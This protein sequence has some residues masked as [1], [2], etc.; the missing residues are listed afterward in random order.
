MQMS[1][2]QHIEMVEAAFALLMQGGASETAPMEYEVE[3][4]Y[5]DHITA[6]VGE[7]EYSIAYEMGEAGVTFA[8]KESWEE[9]TSEAPAPDAAPADEQLAMDGEPVKALGGGKVGGYLV[10]FSTARDPDV[11]SSRDYFDAKTDLRYPARIDTYYHHGMDAKIGKRVIGTTIAT[12]DGAGLWAETQLN[13][14]DEYERAIYEMAQA[15]KLGYSS[16]AL[17]HL[18]EREPAGK[19]V[20]W[21]KTWAIGE[22]SLTPTPAE[23]RNHATPLKSL[24]NP[25]ALAL[26]YFKTE[27]NK[28]DEIQ[29]AVKAALEAER[30]AQ[31]AIQDRA[32]EIEAA[33]QEGAKAAIEELKSQGALRQSPAYVK[34][35]GKSD[36]G[37]AGFKSW[38]ATGQVNGDLIRPTGEMWTKA[39]FN[40]TTGATGGFLVPD[41]LYN[42]IIAKRNN[43]SWVR[44]APVQMFSVTAD[45]LLIPVEDTSATAFVLTAEA[46]AY[47]Q[48]EPTVAQ[49]NLILYKYTKKVQATEEFMMNQATNFD[50]W[51]S[52]V[53]ARAEAVTENAIFTTGTGT[54]QPQGVEVGATAGNTVTTS[55]VL[56]P[57][58]FS[59]LIGQLGS[60]YNVPSECGFLMQ[61]ATKWYAKGLSSS[62]QFAF[63]PTPAGGP[64]DFFGYTAWVD[65]ELDA[66][67]V[68]SSS[69][70][71]LLFGNFNFYAVGE[72]PGMLVQ[73]DPYTNMGT[74]V[75]N[76]YANIYR[77]G[78]VLQ[79]EAFYYT[80]GK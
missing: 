10:R 22:A 27:K 47:D 64:S 33:K 18:V 79:S 26:G 77:G 62:T 52:Q 2:E 41:P 53:L 17:S 78:L 76:I 14:R 72:K 48:N 25:G 73:R 31:K 35:A 36:D 11:S 12:K 63:N 37:M 68:A 44:Q 3:E 80:Q 1:M 67:T 29:T 19:G 70:H 21:I 75:V 24:P 20:N 61:N 69:G 23:P 45:H 46:A 40:Q 42:Q 60:G 13:M 55:A 38:L 30:A 28:M 49:K 4:V 54:G 66:Y 9:M 16:G 58:D 50:S 5:P 74:G 71:S 59:A 56:V 51:I 6:K 7:T 57:A 65:D 39:A 43:A 32:A 34:E 8:P 15:G